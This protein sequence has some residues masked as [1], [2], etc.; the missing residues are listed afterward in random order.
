MDNDLRSEWTYVSA[1]SLTDT[2]S[3][4][5]KKYFM[6]LQAIEILSGNAGVQQAGGALKGQSLLTAQFQYNFNLL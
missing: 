4:W 5:T 3:A 1:V 2:Q 6:K